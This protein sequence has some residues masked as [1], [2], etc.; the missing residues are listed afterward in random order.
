[1]NIPGFICATKSAGINARE[2]AGSLEVWGDQWSSMKLLR[3][4][5]KFKR[6]IA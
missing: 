6:L 2:F 4:P 1:M 3:R 5:E